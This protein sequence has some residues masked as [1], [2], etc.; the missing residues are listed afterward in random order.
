MVGVAREL[1][2]NATEKMLHWFV[3]EQVE[4]EANTSE[5]VQQLDDSW[6]TGSGSADA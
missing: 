3:E 4:E 5:A 2:D 6:E 1:N